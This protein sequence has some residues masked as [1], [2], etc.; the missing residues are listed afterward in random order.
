[1]DEQLIEIF[2]TTLNLPASSITD[3]MSPANTEQWDSL[4]KMLLLAA[5]EETF[6]IELTTEQ[7]EA[8]VDFG[9]VRAIVSQCCMTATS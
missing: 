6:N 8:M 3:S 9:E 7:I 2:A 4:A 1:M 5:I